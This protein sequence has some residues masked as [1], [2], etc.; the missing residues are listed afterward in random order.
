MRWEGVGGGEKIRVPACFADSK[1]SP[2]GRCEV[3]F[4]S[5]GGARPNLGGLRLFGA[6]LVW[7]WD[8]TTTRIF[9]KQSKPFYFDC[10]VNRL[11]IRDGGGDEAI[12][13]C[14]IPPELVAILP[15]GCRRCCGT[16]RRIAALHLCSSSLGFSAVKCERCHEPGTS[17]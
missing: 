15:T 10:C 3:W 7:A 14:A 11:R 16:S 9:C 4:V 6:S 1:C 17:E 5:L 8:S 2:A 12:D 13:H